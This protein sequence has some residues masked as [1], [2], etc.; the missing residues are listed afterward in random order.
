MERIF[1]VG[2]PNCDEKFYANY[3]ELR[4]AGIELLC[5][6]CRHRFHPDAAAWLDERAKPLSMELNA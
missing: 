5:P 3:G 6:Y 1:W 4:E 2:C